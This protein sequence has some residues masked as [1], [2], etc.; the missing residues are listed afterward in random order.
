[1][2]GNFHNKALNI[3]SQ[4]HVVYVSLCLNLDEPVAHGKH[5]LK[6]KK[7]NPVFCRSSAGQER[8]KPEARKFSD[9]V[10]LFYRVFWQNGLQVL[11]EE[12]P[13]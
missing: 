6:Q 5:R 7:L 8:E 3:A 12:L 4:S 11:R 1:M 9:S 2:R 13:Q 10:F